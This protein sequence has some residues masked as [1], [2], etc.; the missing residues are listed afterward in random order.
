MEQKRVG[1]LEAFKLFF[2]NYVNFEGRSTRAEYWWVVLWNLIISTIFI[3]GA[4]LVFISAISSQEMGRFIWLLPILLLLVIYSLGTLIPRISLAVRRYRDAG[5]NPL[6]VI[7]TYGLPYVLGQITSIGNM[8]QGRQALTHEV[9]H[10]FFIAALTSS[11]GGSVLAI[12]SFVTII[13]CEIFNLVVLLRPSKF[14]AGN[15]HPQDD[16]MNW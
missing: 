13:A 14:V 15:P 16:Q 12:L 7:L 10:N 11:F 5:F 1:F 8:F 6:L 4:V 2:K 3:G 9:S